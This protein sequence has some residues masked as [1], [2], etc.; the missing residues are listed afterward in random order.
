MMR[1][2]DIAE[3]LGAYLEGTLESEYRERVE[4]HLAKCPS[5]L[6]ELED[7]RKTRDILADLDDVEPPP[8]LTSQ[9]MSRI[10]K[11]DKAKGFLRRLFFP[12]YI[13]IPVQAL[14]TLLVI[15]LSVY[16]YRSSLPEMSDIRFSGKPNQT[17][18]T[19]ESANRQVPSKEESDTQREPK[20]VTI[21]KKDEVKIGGSLNQGSSR[22][23]AAR[24]S[25][26][27]KNNE[28]QD[29]PE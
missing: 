18:E 28:G 6:Q 11:Q 20:S 24:P 8:W 5:C 12:L 1:C 4:E 14:A 26:G 9:I 7:L 22:A 17:V 13:K 3:Y 27:M 23:D 15:V 16:V 21:K 19:G 25:P 29:I 10:G 2:G